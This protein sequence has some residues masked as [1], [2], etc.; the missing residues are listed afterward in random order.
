M[1]IGR[2]QP[3]L[4]AVGA[5]P[6]GFRPDQADAGAAGVEVHF[7]GRVE[8][9]LDVALGEVF[10]RAVRAVDHADL[11][12]AWQ[13][14][15]RR[16]RWRQHR[17]LIQRCQVQHVTGTQRPSAMAAELAEGEGAFTAQVIRHLHAALQAQ[18]AA[19]PGPRDVADGEGGAGS[20]R[21]RRVHRHRFTV[22]RE[23]NHRTGHRHPR[24]AVEAQQRPV[25]GDF[26]GRRA[27]CVAQEAIAQ[28]Q[29]TA[30]HRSRRRHPHR[31][32]TEAAGIVL[33]AGL[34]AGAEH[35]NGVGAIDQRFQAAG[36]G[37]A[38]GKR[39]VE[40]NLL[41]V[42]AVGLDAVQQAFVQRLMQA[43][44]CL[45]AGWRPAD[46]LGDHRVEVG[47]DLATGLDPGVD[48]QCLAVGLGKS[49]R[50]QQPRAW[51]E[52]PA[53]VLGIQ[54]RLDRVALGFQT[55]A[56]F[57]QWRQI[58]GRQLHHPAHQVH[59]PH[60]LGD[61]VLHLQAGVHF[62]EIEAPRVAVEHELHGA[63]AAVVH[64][65]GQLDR[66]CAEFIGHALGQVRRRGLFEDFLVAPLHRA[67]A[68][69]QGDH[70]AQAIA[71][72]LHFQMPRAFDVLLDEHSGVAEVVLAQALHGFE[73]FAQ[74]GGAAAHTHADAATARGTFE[75]HR[76]AEL[77]A[78]Q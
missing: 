61:A 46:D 38:A 35:F 36:P 49:H 41:Q 10:G 60:L 5:D 14:Q 78:R 76:I 40:E 31:P 18:V 69:A 71:E 39:C 54:A 28:A 15:D 24:G 65:L 33:D 75:H 3:S 9:R 43:Q 27:F 48:A 74:V 44:A 62:Q 52:I 2:V 21:Q 22:E 72:Y 67:V 70:L 23:G 77:S 57:A 30:V 55:L 29:R 59:A 50:S 7:P 58:T 25:H 16:A 66:R 56:Q 6:F 45:L 26:Q 19:R 37:L 32:I 34:G 47:R 13:F 4:A 17:V 53:W 42:V 68:H 8:E 51:L 20:N 1:D 11:P 12:H 63:G 64:G 73:G